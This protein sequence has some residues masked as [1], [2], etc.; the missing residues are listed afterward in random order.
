MTPFIALGYAIT[1]IGCFLNGCCYGKVTSLPWGLV[2]PAID[3]L[4][5]H[6]TQLYASAAALFI[7]LLLRY[8]RKH[9]TFHGFIFAYFL[10]QYGIYRFVVEFF[11][12]SLPTV[13]IFTPAQVMALFFILAG[14]AMLLVHQWKHRQM[15]RS[16]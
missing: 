8:L 6:P 4:P 7:F 11:R 13:W 3:N 10:I 2:Y 1:R 12:V 9:K 16:V 5:R 14:G 15:G